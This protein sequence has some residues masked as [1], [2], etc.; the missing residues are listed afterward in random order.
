V[1]LTAIANVVNANLSL[2]WAAGVA[3]ENIKGGAGADNFT[4][5]A[6]SNV[7]TGGGGNDTLNGGA[8]DDTYVFDVDLILGSD[9]VTDPGGID[10]L[11]FSST[12]GV[13][14][15]V[16]LTVA[17]AQ[18][19]ATNL[20]LTLGASVVEN[21]TGGDG[22]DTITGNGSDNV[23]IGNRGVDILNGNNG[24]D[25]LN[26]GDGNDTLNGG[27]DNDTYVFN[28]G[29]AQGADSLTDSGGIDTLD[30]SATAAFSVSVNLGLTT[31][32]VVRTGTLTITLSS[33]TAFENVIGGSGNDTLIGNTSANVF[34][35]GAGSDIITGVGAGDTLS[36]TR[37]ANFVLADTSV[38]AGTLTIGAEVDTLTNIHTAILTGG[39]SNN[40][41]DVR[42]FTGTATLNGGSGS[43]T[44]YGGGGTMNLNGGFGDDTYVFDRSV[45]SVNIITEGSG[46]LDDLHDTIMGAGGGLVNLTI[47][48]LQVPDA[49]YPNFKIQFTTGSTVEHTL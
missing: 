14:L 9:T 41:I 34:T 42:D 21:V 8:G 22:N 36:E 44:L 17:A 25:T 28:A 37:D 6:L 11:D 20:T 24:A 48:G 18:V 43:D 10:T 13:N 49:A 1:N 16:N 46:F 40:I 35:G 33:A 31:A 38:S 39:I 19:V 23:L 3:L 45:N 26:G 30:L 29:I 12:T 47:A 5:T 27:A 7:L 4:G 32:Q 2:N 15:N